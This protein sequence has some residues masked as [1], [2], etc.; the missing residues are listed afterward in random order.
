[1][2]TYHYD[3]DLVV[4]ISGELNKW[5]S[6][7]WSI[8][9]C[10]KMTHYKWHLHLPGV[11]ELTYLSWL[12]SAWYMGGL[13]LAERTSKKGLEQGKNSSHGIHTSISVIY[14]NGGFTWKKIMMLDKFYLQVLNLLTLWGRVTHICV[15]KLSIIGSDNG[16]SPGQCQAMV[17]YC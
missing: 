13:N 12:P 2:F 9:T 7:N 4:F 10:L 16:L 1:M 3:W 5:C 17:E 8:E 15:G 6:R 11:N 14:E